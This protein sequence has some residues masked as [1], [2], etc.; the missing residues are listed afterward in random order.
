M[1]MNR[2]T[3]LNAHNDTIINGYN[4]L[5]GRNHITVF[6]HSVGLRMDHCQKIHLLLL[7]V[8]FGRCSSKLYKL[9]HRFMVHLKFAICI[10]LNSIE[11][12]NAH[13]L[14]ATNY[15]SHAHGFTPQKC[16]I[17]SV[18]HPQRKGKGKGVKRFR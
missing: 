11:P 17:S 8:Y 12:K 9:A 16:F 15:Q 3:L 18:H 1:M 14:T 6:G 2:R 4:G 10:W 13:T 7:F 5:L